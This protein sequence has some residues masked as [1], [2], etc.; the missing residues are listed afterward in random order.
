MDV[1]W[2]RLMAGL[3]WRLRAVE[4][5]W[6]E[7]VVSPRAEQLRHEQVRQHG[8]LEGRQGEEGGRLGQRERTRRIAAGLG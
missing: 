4:A 8:R 5:L 1:S 6:R 7:L 3:R 2:T